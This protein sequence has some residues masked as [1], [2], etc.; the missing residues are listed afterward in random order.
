MN[1]LEQSFDSLNLDLYQIALDRHEE[2]TGCSLLR[3]PM[4]SLSDAI[5]RIRKLAF[6]LDPKANH[7]VPSNMFWM[8]KVSF[9][10]GD[11]DLHIAGNTGEQITFRRLTKPKGSSKRFNL[12]LAYSNIFV[13]PT[14]KVETSW[15][16][17]SIRGWLRIKRPANISPHII[18]ATLV[19]EGNEFRPMRDTVYPDLRERGDDYIIPFSLVRL[20]LAQLMASFNKLVILTG[21]QEYFTLDCSILNPQS[22]Q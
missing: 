8:G 11:H 16:S 1:L 14:Y 10:F 3:T 13:K 5:E 12:R 7:T 4:T 20:R 2:Q 22:K 6:L 21:T 15:V 19:K 17:S 18:N 9:A